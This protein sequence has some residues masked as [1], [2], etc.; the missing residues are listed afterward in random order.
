MQQLDTTPPGGDWSATARRR[1]LLVRMVPGGWP[2]SRRW[3]PLGSF[4]VVVST[5]TLNEFRSPWNGVPVETRAA[6][7][8]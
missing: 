2:L 5:V 3:N 6:P 7:G 1:T 8:R 4:G